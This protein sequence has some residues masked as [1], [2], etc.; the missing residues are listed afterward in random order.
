MKQLSLNDVLIIKSR[1]SKF[2]PLIKGDILHTD[3]YLTLTDATKELEELQS[4]APNKD[5]KKGSED[6][7]WDILEET[8]EISEENI[9]A[10]PHC[11]TLFKCGFALIKKSTEILDMC[12]DTEGMIARMDDLYS[13]AQSISEAVDQLGSS[14]YEDEIPSSSALSLVKN[15]SNFI[16][17]LRN[18]TDKLNKEQ[19]EQVNKFLSLLESKLDSTWKELDACLSKKP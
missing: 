16:T 1:L 18:Q 5:S 13:S 6:S 19:S 12:K 8:P 9:K 2:L 3:K 10:L 11:V 4:A 14:L 17:L 7:R 15:N